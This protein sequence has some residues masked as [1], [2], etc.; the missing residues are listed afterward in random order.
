MESSSI[1]VVLLFILPLVYLYFHKIRLSCKSKRLPPGR[2]GWP[3]LGESLE[4]LSKIQQGIPYE[5]AKERMNKYSSTV[6]RTSLIGQNMVMFCGAEGNKFLFSNEKKLVQVWWPCTM[7][8]IFPKSDNRPSSEHSKKLRKMLPVILRTDVLREFVG[9]MDAIMKD[10]LQKYWNRKNVNVSD[11]AK[12]YLLTLACSTFLGIDDERKVDEL[13]K[14][15]EDIGSGIHS[16]PF[17]LP[18][19]ALNR[20]IKASKIMRK[21][22]E[23]MIHQRRI[24]LSENNSPS[25]SPKD[26][27]SHILLEK[28]DNG[29]F[30][31]DG[32][33]ASHLIGLVQAGYTTVHSTII[34]MMKYLAE[35]PDVY[36]QVLLVKKPNDRLSWEDLWKMKYSWNV[37]LE[38]LR[39]Y[40]PG[41]GSFREAITDL[42]YDGYTIPRGSKIH[43]IFDATHK[44]PEC[45]RDPEIFNPSRFQGDNIAPYTFVPFGGGSRMCPGNEYARLAILVFLHN[46]VKKFRWEKLYP[47]EEV[48]H[49]PVPRPAHGL[50]VHLIPHKP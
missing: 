33:I 16:M 49:Y 20:A 5:F 50:P 32:D 18:G 10:H 6:F 4:Y 25:P 2:T 14:G 46:V 35:L 26:F 45:F 12:K 41:T 44:N 37:A 9:T 48:V 34:I 1:L 36:N 15:T 28:D 47:G 23:A 27:M 30:L 13:A 21:E 7:D 24:D 8:M 11:L 40:T 17:N 29:Q 39:V 38:V 42:V 31:S 22:V 43:W 3:I 19:T